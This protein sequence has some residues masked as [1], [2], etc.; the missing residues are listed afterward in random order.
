M[1]IKLAKL[2]YHRPSLSYCLKASSCF[3]LTY[4]WIGC[5]SHSAFGATWLLYS[6][7]NLRLFFIGCFTLVDCSNLSP[8]SY[9]RKHSTPSVT[10]TDIAVKFSNWFTDSEGTAFDLSAITGQTILRIP[11]KAFEATQPDRQPKVAGKAARI[12]TRSFSLSS[13]E[14]SA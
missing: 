7:V 6:D 13:S 8:Q 11:R 4:S 12:L 3:E 14:S 10:P 1:V 5:S 9:L 2:L